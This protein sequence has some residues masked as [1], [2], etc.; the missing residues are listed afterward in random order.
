MTVPV[1]RGEVRTI[2]LS[3]PD[4]TPTGANPPGIVQKEKRVVL[5]QTSGSNL[6]DVSVVVC[7]SLKNSRPMRPYEVL[8]GVREGFDRETVINCRWVFTVQKRHLRMP[9]QRPLSP[10]VMNQISAALTVGLQL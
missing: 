7:D 8:V 5:L 4:R 9:T 6:T 10:G 2:M 1:N 3:L